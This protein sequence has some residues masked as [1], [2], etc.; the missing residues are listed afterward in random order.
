[1]RRFFKGMCSIM[2]AAALSLQAFPAEMSCLNVKAAEADKE[3]AIA[4]DDTA[5]AATLERPVITSVIND[6]SGAIKISWN[7][8]EGATGYKVYRRTEGEKNY[9]LIDDKI[10]QLY[11]L[12]YE[13]CSGIK[14]YYKVEAYNKT[15]KSPRSK[16]VS[17]I[18][19]L[20]PHFSLKQINGSDVDIY[21]YGYTVFTEFDAYQIYRKEKGTTNWK[22]LATVPGKDV[23]E[24]WKEP[25][26]ISDN[27]KLYT[28]T[29]TEYGHTYVYMLRG[30]KGKYKS[31]KSGWNTITVMKTPSIKSA[32]Y[33][34][35]GVDLSWT[36][37]KGT[38]FYRISYY[39]YNNGWVTI[40]DIKIP[41]NETSYHLDLS[42]CE[43]YGEKYDDNVPLKLRVQA[44]TKW[45]RKTSKEYKVSG[46]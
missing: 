4:V 13:T 37:V 33:S 34:D 12:D 19:L 30:I 3:Q 39:S 24:E 32:V 10:T 6:N 38:M 46:K 42:K 40:R 21:L 26:W 35:D 22:K 36:R 9:K 16:A 44:R 20:E 2:I 15:L 1:M 5:D 28:D 8:V 17:I 41:G 45:S 23:Q 29:D 11:D 27:N 43:E 14:Y 7:E 25:N 18:D 31:A